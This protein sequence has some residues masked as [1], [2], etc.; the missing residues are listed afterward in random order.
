M[1]A[2]EA[3]LQDRIQ[4][5]LGTAMMVTA[6]LFAV[7][8]FCDRMKMPLFAM[9]AAWYSSRNIHLVL[10]GAMFIAAA[11][12]L[13][14]PGAPRHDRNGRPL[15]RTC[16]LYTRA[17]CH[18]CEEAFSTLMQFQ[19]AL[20]NID[21]VDIDADPQLIRQFGESVPVVEIDGRVRFRGAVRPALLQRLI[22]A[23]E[24]RE[25]QEAEALAGV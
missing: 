2:R 19:D 24:L 21:V 9:P 16:R 18:L 25:E 20:P 23:A 22:D 5:W 13:K 17:E 12:L 11:V 15:F 6:S 3:D 7:L 1:N 4:A 14:S 10:C 8:I